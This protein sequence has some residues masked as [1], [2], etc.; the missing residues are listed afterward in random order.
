M[1]L[2]YFLCA[3]GIISFSVWIYQS[4]L[5]P[6]IRQRLRFELFQLRD[7]T[8]ELVIA[9]KLK[10]DSAIFYHLHRQIN[11]LIK[12]IPALDIAFVSAIEYEK[13]ELEERAARFQDL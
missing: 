6:S 10:E 11:V 8:R 9:G 1:M 3:F 5:L 7:Q 13:R 4:I 12:A 2:I